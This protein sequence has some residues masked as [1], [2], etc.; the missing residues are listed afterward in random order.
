MRSADLISV[1]TFTL[2]LVAAGCSGGGGGN[3]S[4]QQPGIAA[5]PTQPTTTPAPI[6]IPTT[7]PIPTPAP[8][9]T[10]TPIPP[11]YAVTLSWA[12]NHESGIN[13][14]GGGYQVSVSGQ[15]TINVPYTSGPT[16]PTT[17]TF[18]LHEGTYIV[19]I[20][21]YAMLDPRG[22]NTGSLSA[23]SQSIIVIVP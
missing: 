15:P 9:A 13:S 17:T 5:P 14:A 20:R 10:P 8:T 1:A 4:S 19:S 2:G 16:A 12:S 11:S 22:G 3:D 6:P 23:A 18:S 7:P 21:A